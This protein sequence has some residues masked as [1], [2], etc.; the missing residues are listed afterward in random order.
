MNK[1]I[2][3]GR[4]TQDIELKATASGTE[5]ADFTLAVNRNYKNA[6][7]NYEADFINCVSYKGLAKTISTYVKKGDRLAVEG[8]LQTRTYQN[9]EGKNIKVSEVIVEN[10]DFIETKKKEE[11]VGIVGPYDGMEKVEVSA[12]SF[13]GEQIDAIPVPNDPFTEQMTITDDFESSLPF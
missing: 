9:K 4:V 12:G 1:I 7:G 3:I 10:I 5:V 2:L 6:E 11:K 8:R 13:K